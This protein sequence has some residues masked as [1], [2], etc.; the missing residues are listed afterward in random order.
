MDPLKEADDLPK[1]LLDIQEMFF[2]L[3]FPN[4]IKNFFETC[5]LLKG[6]KINYFATQLD[7]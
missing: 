5:F 6:K 4:G 7:L 3:Y 1:Y 2:F